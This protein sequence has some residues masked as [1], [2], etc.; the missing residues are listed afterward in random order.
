M[1]ESSS[2]LCITIVHSCGMLWLI[3]L[4]S[5]MRYVFFRARIIVPP[6]LILKAG[7][8]RPSGLSDVAVRR[9]DQ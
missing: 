8:W 2:S 5:T 6:E 4:R 9:T 7:F 1:I 3:E